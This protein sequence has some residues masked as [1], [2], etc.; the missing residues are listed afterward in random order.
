[1]MAVLF[2]TPAQNLSVN[3]YIY[4][5]IFVY[6]CVC[7]LTKCVKL[8]VKYC[9]CKKYMKRILIYICVCV[10]ACLFVCMLLF[11]DVGDVFLIPLVWGGGENIFS[12]G[13][14]YHP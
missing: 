8:I 12:L 14:F 6:V 4:I 7:T 1:M 10:C 2:H 5:D 11:F 3:T 9:V 13:C